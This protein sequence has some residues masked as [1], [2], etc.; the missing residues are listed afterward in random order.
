MEPEYGKWMLRAIR[1]AARGKG[2][3]N[4][5]PLVGAV[6]I[7]DGR[8][9][10]EGYH[11]RFGGPHAEVNA[12]AAAGDVAGATLVVTLEPCIHQGKTPP[13]APM[14]AEKGIREVVIGMTDPNPLVNG[15][16]IRFLES[17]GIRVITG[18]HEKRVREQNESFIKFI[19]TGLPFCVLKTGM[20][21]DGKIATATGE[22]KWITGESSRKRA[23]EMRQEAGALVTGIDT[24]L[25]DDPL[26]NVRRG[27]KR[28]R[29]A[30]KVIVDSR[31][32]I[33]LEANLLA[34]DPQL[35]VIAAT[36][37]AP[38]DK[39]KELERL[40]V[41][42][43]I[44]PEINGRVDLAYL[45]K[46][47]GTMDIDR[48]MIESGGT[49]AFS[50]IRAGIVDRVTAFIAPKIIGGSDAPTAIGGEGIKNLGDAFTL[51]NIKV[52]KCGEDIMIEGEL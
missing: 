45:M 27:R 20:S 1:L 19:R 18:V 9:I 38:A 31:A 4:P 50:A 32:R 46:A 30:L 16:G 24:V 39:R 12:I 48:V 36:E 35:V 3:V 37:K 44:C 26:L 13:C 33:P 51:R 7:K 23:H 10:G 40:G 49:L 52:R 17:Q 22:S 2:W 5:N 15:N 41:H 29:N 21:L 25:A 6:L 42:V 11:E 14:L 34:D 28:S 47:L 8:I 43:L